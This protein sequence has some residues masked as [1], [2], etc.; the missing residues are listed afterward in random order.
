MIVIDNQVPAG[1]EIQ[2]RQF[3]NIPCSDGEVLKLDDNVIVEKKRI[4]K[5]NYG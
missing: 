4:S 3:L 5:A 1:M 2:C